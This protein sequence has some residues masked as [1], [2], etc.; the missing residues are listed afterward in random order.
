MKEKARIRTML[1]AA[2]AAVL[3][4]CA[5]LT[6]FLGRRVTAA[7]GEMLSPVY[8]LDFADA[9]DRGKNSALSNI[10]SAEIVD[11]GGVT[12][13]NDGVRGA[14][15][16]H[17]TSGGHHV[18]Y[19]AIPGAVLDS[20]SVTVA[21]WFRIDG[22]VPAFS[23]LLELNNGKAGTEQFSWLSV[24]PFAP[25]M[26][27]GLH[28][29]CGVNNRV[30]TGADGAE[31]IVFEGA[32]P[33]TTGYNTPRAG[34]ILPVYD[35]WVH[36]AYRLTPEGFSLFQNG[37]LT[38]T[39]AG[40]FTAS[41]FYSD[42]A[43]LYLGTTFSAGDADFTGAFSDIRVYAAALDE[44]QLATEFDL[45][46]TD[47]LTASYDFENG[48][49]DAVRGYDGTFCGNAA[50]TDDADKGGKVLSLD[51]RNA[52]STNQTMS[53]M[54][55]PLKTL[56]GHNELTV[57]VDVFVDSD[58]ANYARIFDFSVRGGQFLS[59]GAKWG[60]ATAL[61][62][63]YTRLN[64]RLDWTVTADTLFNRWVNITVTLD[65]TR[66]ALY[67]D[68]LLAAEN[69]D[70]VYKN[71][72]F[73]EGADYAMTVGRT[74]YYDDPPFKGSMDNIKIYQKAMTEKEVMLEQGVTNIE[75]DAQAVAQEKQ[76]LYLQ[77]DGSASKIELPLYGGEGVRIAWTSSRPDV[78]T[79]EGNVLPPVTDTTVTLTA[80]LSRGG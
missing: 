29:H 8:K 38:K 64:D 51:G 28:V 20:D 32:D 19:A 4:L 42:T 3:L 36:Y 48:A 67:L 69:A 68:G 39:V 53:S 54:D 73:W 59:L 72:I 24:M 33:A 40:D 66:A 46:Y 35:A 25:S 11:G 43:K 31:N 80:S 60:N 74:Q 75:D 23:R 52:G 79:E 41:Q 70:F 1:T 18:N 63:K 34:F 55:L 45:T 78:I 5:V 61:M 62:L 14:A 49:A 7:S 2:F 44:R 76:K 77:W 15:A 12:Y 26:Y 10:G 37:K 50:A 30:R 21:G 47:F 16:M 58:C 71:S 17:L 65:G 22:A 6:V 57:S 9:A 27:N 56:H 13:A